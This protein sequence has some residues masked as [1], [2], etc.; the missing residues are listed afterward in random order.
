MENEFTDGLRNLA[1]TKPADVSAIGVKT[2]VEYIEELESIIRGMFP[3]WLAAMGYCEHNRF[4]DLMA[5]QNYYNGKDNPMTSKDIH[6]MF[7]LVD[8]KENKTRQS[9]NH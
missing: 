8:R 7:S 4:N 1:K 2:M 3:L 9:V 6:L 5:M